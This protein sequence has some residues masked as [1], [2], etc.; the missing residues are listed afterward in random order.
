MCPSLQTDRDQNYKCCW[1]WGLSGR[2]GF[3]D[4]LFNGRR[5]TAEIVLRSSCKVLFIIHGSW[6][7]LK[8]LYAMQAEWWIWR[9]RKIRQK[10]AETQLRRYSVLQVCPSL[11]TNCDQT[12]KCFWTWGWVLDS[13]FQETHLNGRRDTAKKV[14]C[15]ASRAP[16]VK[17][18]SPRTLQVF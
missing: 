5:Y 2:Y 3:Q 10:E 7:K 16:F 11:L 13:K 1:P 9:F 15:S 8:V 4:S 14:L 18:W 17:D 12:Y 6:P